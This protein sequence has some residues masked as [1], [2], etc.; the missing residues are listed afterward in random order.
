MAGQWKWTVEAK[1]FELVVRGGNIGVRFYERNSKTNRSI[2][3]QR[4]EVAWL[5]SVVEELLAVKTS[6][7]FWDQSR[8]GYPRIFAEKCSNRHG[9]FLTI[10]EFDNKK[11]CGSIMIPEGRHGQGWERLKSEVSRANSLLSMGE[12]WKSKK[13]TLGRSYAEV[14]KETQ[15]GGFEAHTL[16]SRYIPARLVNGPQIEPAERKANANGG[17]REF[18]GGRRGKERWCSGVQWSPFGEYSQDTAIS[19]KFGVEALRGR[20]ESAGDGSVSLG[21]MGLRV[22]LQ[23]IKSFLTKL[24]ENVDMG[25]KKVEVV[26][27]SLEVGGLNL[28]PGVG[29]NMG[30]DKASYTK[31]KPN[32]KNRKRKNKNKNIQSGPKPGIS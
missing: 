2:F 31:S 3:L 25:I 6:E 5:D 9:N 29:Q 15:A 20:F 11:R 18:C 17:G 22:E 23:E 12:K 19:R 24:K 30:H 16:K 4:A 21:Q 28:G 1:E 32:R 7:V 27:G 13:V 26:M 8:A 10:E 14:V